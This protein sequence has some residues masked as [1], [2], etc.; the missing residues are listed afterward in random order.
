MLSKWKILTFYSIVQCTN[1]WYNIEVESYKESKFI[2]IKFILTG[3]AK[4]SLDFG[5]SGY[6]NIVLKN[7]HKPMHFYESTCKVSTL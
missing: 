7:F 5:T 4:F 6:Q 3:S 2:K 1:K